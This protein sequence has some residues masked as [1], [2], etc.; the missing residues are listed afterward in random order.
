MIDLT[1]AFEEEE[2]EGIGAL[3]DVVDGQ[4]LNS[5]FLGSIKVCQTLY[6]IISELLDLILFE[7]PINKTSHSCIQMPINVLNLGLTF[8]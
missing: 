4:F 5:D 8:I 7:T 1:M 3:S 6:V 2:Y